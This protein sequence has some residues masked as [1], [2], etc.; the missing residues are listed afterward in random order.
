MF[1]IIYT[2]GENNINYIV[3]DTRRLLLELIMS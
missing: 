3:E 2:Y 1:A